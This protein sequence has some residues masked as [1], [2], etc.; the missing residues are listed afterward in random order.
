MVKNNLNFVKINEPLM[1]Y[2]KSS[3]STSR[4]KK[5]PKK[6]QLNI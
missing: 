3:K 4:F 6:I 1:Y 2:Y 5:I